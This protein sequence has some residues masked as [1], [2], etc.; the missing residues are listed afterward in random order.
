MTKALAGKG[1]SLDLDGTLYRVVRWRVAW[2][3]RRDM[4][5]LKSMLKV[6]DRIRE[7]PA[8]AGEDGVIA[9]EAELLAEQWKCSQETM[10]RDLVELKVK[11][12]RAATYRAKPFAGVV[13]SLHWAVEQGVQLAVFSDYAPQDK[14][15]YLGLSGLP[16]V[17]CL[18]AENIGALK[19]HPRGFI[20]VAEAMGLPPASILHVGDREDLDIKGAM[21]AGMKTAL[22][23][24]KSD[25]TM[26]KNSLNSWSESALSA[27]FERAWP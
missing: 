7:A 1:L 17:L 15:R 16:W 4:S 14:L 22:F 18:G 26:G 24:P 3:L 6:R 2:R 27:L 10:R 9:R 5:L 21:A 12:A 23:D 11:M 8:L 19:P 20:R 25:M 13:R